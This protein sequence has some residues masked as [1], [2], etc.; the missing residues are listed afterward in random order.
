ML[1]QNSRE[2]GER[3]Q[4]LPVYPCN[5]AVALGVANAKLVSG[6]TVEVETPKPERGVEVRITVSMPFDEFD[7]SVQLVNLLDYLIKNVPLTNIIVV[8]DIA[9]GSTTIT[10]ELSEEDAAALHDALTSGKL[11]DL[12]IDRIFHRDFSITRW[13]AMRAVG[14]RNRHSAV[15]VRTVYAVE[16]SAAFRRIKSA[17]EGISLRHRIRSR[18]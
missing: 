1:G 3:C 10:I 4:R 11:K 13:F 6:G 15:G 16:G 5:F 14:C 2:C 9:S 12:P 7:Q 18:R 8:K 17:R